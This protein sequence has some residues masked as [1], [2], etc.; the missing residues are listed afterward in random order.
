M[1]VSME[2]SWTSR[3]K[4][5]RITAEKERVQYIFVIKVLQLMEA[6][7]WDQKYGK[8]PVQGYGAVGAR[9]CKWHQNIFN[10]IS[11]LT[12]FIITISFP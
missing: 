11:Y 2:K 6:P 5:L 8:G 9:V 3:G 10:L 12:F 7:G 1:V 4:R